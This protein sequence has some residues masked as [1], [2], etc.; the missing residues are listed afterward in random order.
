M[1]LLSILRRSVWRLA[2]FFCIGLFVSSIFIGQA[3]TQNQNKQN[4]KDCIE[5]PKGGD[6]IERNRR[7]A[8]LVQADSLIQKGDFAEAAKL[9]QTVKKP[10]PSGMGALI[11]PTRDSESLDGGANVYWR[12]GQDGLKQGLESKSLIN[13]G[14]LSENYPEFIPGHI[15]FAEASLRWNQP[16]KAIA[17]LDRAYGLYPDRLDI[18]EPLLPLLTSKKLF[19]EASVAS[20]Q[21]GLNYPEHPDSAKYKKLA[22]EYLNQFLNDFRTDALVTGVIS[23][24]NG[25]RE[26]KVLELILKGESDFGKESAEEIKQSASLV[27]EPK[28]VDYINTIGQKLAKSAGRDDFN[29]EFNIVQDKALNAFALPGGKIF[30]NTGTIADV[31][32]EAE[33]AGILSHEIAHAVFSHSYLKITTETKTNLLKG[34]SFF[35]TF[36]DITKPELSFGRSLE[37]QADVLGTRI[38]AA[39]GYSADGLYRVFD[40]WSGYDKNRST[41]WLDTHPA[42]SE[43][44][45]YLQAIIANRN[46]NRYS[47]EKI[48]AL[49]AARGELLC[50]VDKTELDPK[51]PSIK[52]PEENKLI[53]GDVPLKAL[54]T[55]EDVTISINGAKVISSG[56]YV[57]NLEITNNSKDDFAFVPAFAKVANAEGK[58]VSTAFTSKADKL[59]LVTPNETVKANFAIYQQPWRPNASQDLILEIKEV[60]KGTRVFRIPF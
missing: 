1:S 35:K 4:K 12:D 2:L 37:Q 46:Y 50:A 17:T 22:D 40:R 56:N 32:S 48:E 45:R 6:A 54:L 29:Y 60:T 5:I 21:F 55:K 52:K 31:E 27:T 38:L 49:A 33:L 9:Q 59:L 53:P 8:V 25:S 15:K 36:L 10:F 3:E 57:L 41:G 20:R 16:E 26:R 18:L 51:P 13:L 47:L 7:I 28:L 24:F 11:A 42:S 58:R 30:I 43:R 14:K 39:A 23:I 19:V 44:V 34:I